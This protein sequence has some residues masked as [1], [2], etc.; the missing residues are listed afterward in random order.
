VIPVT[1]AMVWLDIV[2]PEASHELQSHL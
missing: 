1:A 2:S